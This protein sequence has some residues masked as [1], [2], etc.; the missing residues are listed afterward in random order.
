MDINSV[1][2]VCGEKAFEDDLDWHPEGTHMRHG[3][4]HGQ[5]YDD[6]FGEQLDYE[7]VVKAIHEEIREYRDRGVY[8]KDPLKECSDKTKKKVVG[9]R[10]VAI[11]KGDKASLE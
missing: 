5:F 6:I 9:C 3:G 10:W 7:M 11:N 1:G 4:T 8:E 2:R